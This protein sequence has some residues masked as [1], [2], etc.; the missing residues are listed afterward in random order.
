MGCDQ[1]TLDDDMQLFVN[2]ANAL[3]D[4]WKDASW[5][6]WA[7]PVALMLA[8]QALVRQRQAEEAAAQRARE[9]AQRVIEVARCEEE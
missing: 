2:D 3:L 9:E 8:M 6:S 5:L 7:E 1:W 4:H